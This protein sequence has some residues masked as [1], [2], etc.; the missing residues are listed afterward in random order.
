MFDMSIETTQICGY[1]RCAGA[2]E[3]HHLNRDLKN[4]GIS[5]KGTLDLG[6]QSKK[7]WKNA[8]CYAQI[9]IENYMQ[10]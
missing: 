9:V 10:E 6:W 7:N 3:F 1:C 5:E 8:S 2:L 4:F